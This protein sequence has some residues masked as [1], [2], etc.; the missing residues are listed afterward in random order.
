M[1]PAML[2]KL[3]ENGVKTLDDLADLA[4]DELA[5]F[6]A[7]W[8]VSIDDCNAIVMAA[9]AHWFDDGEE[10]VADSADGEAGHAEASS[11]EEASSEEASSEE[12]SSEEAS[13]EEAAAEEASTAD[14][15]GGDSS[16]EAGQDEAAEEVRQQ[17]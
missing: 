6:L 15:S 17:D 8:N 10:A 9:R 2:V 7:D 12:A 5:E 14:S 4:G 1:S 11:A 13:S 3:G 16:G